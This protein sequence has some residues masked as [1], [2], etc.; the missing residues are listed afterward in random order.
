MLKLTNPFKPYVNKIPAP[1]RNPYFWTLILFVAWMFF[2]DRHNVFTQWDLIK[3]SDKLDH[4]VE[5]YDEKLTEAIQDQKD[6]D[7]NKEKFAREKYY[8]KKHDE[9]VFIIVE[10][11]AK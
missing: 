10:E 5:F 6:L 4:D 8:M 11:E 1:I 9:D 2:F 3:T 7:A